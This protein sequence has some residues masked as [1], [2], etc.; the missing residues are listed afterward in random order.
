MLT[1]GNKT[2]KE[3]APS[4]VSCC[5]VLG[6]TSRDSLDHRGTRP[7]VGEQPGSLLP[8]SHGSSRVSWHAATEFP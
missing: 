1:E 2:L 5:G 6:E 3:V 4:G 7:G 8:R